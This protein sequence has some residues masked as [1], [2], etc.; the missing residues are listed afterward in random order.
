MDDLSRRDFTINAMALDPLTGELGDIYNG[1]HD[2]ANKVIKAVNNPDIRMKED[3]LRILRA[4]RFSITLGYGIE[5]NTFKAMLDN[6]ELLDNISKE[7][8]TSEFRKIFESGKPVREI[9]LKASDII[10]KIIPEMQNCIGFSQNNK[11]H[12]HDVYEHILYVVDYC[13]TTDFEV[14]MAALFHDIAK[15]EAY[16]EGPDGFGHFYGHPAMS[17]DKATLALVKDFRLTTD[18][19]LNILKLVEEH[20]NDIAA[21]KNSVKKLLNVLGPYLREK[22]FILKQADRMDHIYPDNKH[23]MD[24]PKL[25]E[26]F[27]EIIQ[28]N[29]CFKLSDMNISGNDIM[30]LLDIKPGIE[31]GIVLR[32]LLEEVIADEVPNEKEALKERAKQIYLEEIAQ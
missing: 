7:R 27:V 16:F 10:A 5:E 24:I 22:W 28:E 14:K 23:F 20:D 26:I 32:E 21:T 4:L 12:V 8:I 3:P 17:K 31:V 30:N 1:K 13:D 18:E 19:M 11:Y 9:F 15:P 25:K 2:I 29:Q 6:K